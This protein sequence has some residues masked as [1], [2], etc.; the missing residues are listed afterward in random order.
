MQVEAS[1]TER[2]PTWDRSFPPE[3]LGVTVAELIRNPTISF[4]CAKEVW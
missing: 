1:E 4:A 2:L 3:R